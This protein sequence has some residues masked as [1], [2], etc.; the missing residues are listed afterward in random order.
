MGYNANHNMHRPLSQRNPY[1]L[2]PPDR[3]MVKGF[4]RR[5]QSLR[6][7]LEEIGDGN[8]AISYDAQ[9]HGDGKGTALEDLAIK[10]A[11]ISADIDLIESTCYEVGAD[12]YKYLLLGVT[13]YSVGFDTLRRYDEGI[14]CGKN[15]YYKKY[16]QFYYLLFQKLE[17]QRRGN[18]QG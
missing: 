17:R 5:Y 3:D 16:H 1:Y 12:I 15:Y 4:A 10:R 18:D 11:A 8:R 9:P 13:S 7:R 2:S 6:D 14:P